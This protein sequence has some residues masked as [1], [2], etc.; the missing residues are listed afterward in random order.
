MLDATIPSDAN[1]VEAKLCGDLQDTMDVV[2]DDNEV[3]EDGGTDGHVDSREG[4]GLTVV[5]RK[6]SVRNRGPRGWGSTSLSACSIE[7]PSKPLRKSQKSSGSGNSS[8]NCTPE[9][10]CDGPRNVVNG[11]ANTECNANS[12]NTN[13]ASSKRNRFQ[14]GAGVRK[15]TSVAVSVL[16]GLAK[17][18][19]KTLERG[20]SIDMLDLTKGL[21]A[22]PCVMEPPLGQLGNVGELMSLSQL[23]EELKSKEE[24][25]EEEEKHMT[26]QRD[27]EVAHHL[28][29]NCDPHFDL[30]TAT[31]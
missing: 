25:E 9:T 22:K 23:S 14:Q 31:L 16:N 13:K 12:N 2:L 4:S 11:N 8:H 26:P 17:G 24:A 10:S 27:T 19:G 18:L 30:L 28:A 20:A 3:E 21:F 5:R 15:G 7:T 1:R 29:A 6:R